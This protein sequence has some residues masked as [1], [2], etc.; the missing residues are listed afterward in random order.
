MSEAL[1]A[2]NKALDKAL[3][4]GPNEAV[5]KV[6]KAVNATCYNM[7]RQTML[8]SFCLICPGPPTADGIFDPRVLN[9]AL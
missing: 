6:L 5:N 2:L 7:A 4:G 9:K 3:H 8:F 1:N